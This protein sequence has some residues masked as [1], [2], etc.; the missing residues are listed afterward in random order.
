MSANPRNN[1]NKS[2]IKINLFVLPI[3]KAMPLW[4]QD[5]MK[6]PLQMTLNL[7]RQLII[8]IKLF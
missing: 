4:I 3:K 6:G 1:L 2:I 8:K 5:K 7:T